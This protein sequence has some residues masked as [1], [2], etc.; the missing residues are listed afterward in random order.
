MAWSFIRRLSAAAIVLAGGL[1]AGVR[2]DATLDRLISAGKYK[3]AIEHADNN[4]PAP[5][6]NADVWVK[7]GEANE[8]V[9][10]TEKALACYLVAW[11]LDASSYNALLGAAKV[12]NRLGQPENA[13]D[14]AEKALELK[15]TG[16]ASWEYARASIQLKKPQEA[17]KALEKVIETDP[18]NVVANR[19]LGGIYFDEKKYAD[20]IPLLRKA[21][22]AKKDPKLSLRIG[23]AYREVGNLDSALTFIEAAIA[24]GLKSPEIVLDLARIYYG[25][26]QYEEAVR[27]FDQAYGKADFTA[28]D[29]CS[30]AVAKEKTNDKKGALKAYEA[31]VKAYGASTEPEA[32]QANLK[33][34]TAYFEQ[35]NYGGALTRLKAIKKADPK[36]EEVPNIN[37]LL[38]DVYQAMK[39]PTQ[40]IASLEKA[41]AKDTKNYEAYARLAELYEKNGQ[42]EK[43]RQTYEKMMKLSPNDPKVFL[44][45]GLYNLKSKKYEKALEL[46]TKSEQLSP[47]AEAEEGIA[48]AS[49]NLDQ[50]NRAR[51]AALK[52]IQRKPDLV[53]SR[54]ILAKVYLRAEEYGDA[55]KHLEFLVER[56]P[57]NLDHLKDLAESYAALNKPKKLAEVDAKIIAADKKNVKS[58]IRLAEYLLRNKELKGAYTHFRAAS[59]LDPKNA[60]VLGN[61]YRIAAELGKK[62]E[63]VTYVKKYLQLKPKDAERYRDLGDLQYEL[64]KWEGA[65]SAYRTALKLDPGLTGFYKRYADVVLKKGQQAEVIKALTTLIKRGQGDMSAYTTL[66]TLYEKQKQYKKALDVY[67]QALAIEP[68]NA[69]LLSSYASCQAKTGDINGAIITYEQAVMMNPKAKEEFRSLGRLYEKQKKP[70]QA[71][72]AY[73]K[74]L[75]R[76]AKDPKV[77]QNVGKY[78]IEKGKFDVAYKYLST[79]QGEAANDFDHLLLLGEAAFEIGKY[80]ETVGAYTR[81]LERKPKMAVKKQLTSTLAKAYEK[82]GN[83]VDAAKMYAAYNKLAG[84]RDAEAAYKSARL[85]EKANPS[86]AVAIYKTNV[87]VFP[88]DARNFLRLGLIYSKDKKKLQSS[89]AMLK[90]A[91]S[92]ADTVPKVWLELAQVYGE[93]GKEDDELK[94]YKQYAKFDAQNVLANKRIGLL[95]MKKGQTRDGMIYLETANALSPDDPEVMMALA[96]G[97]VQTNR[98]KEAIDL[99]MRVKKAQPKNAEVRYRIFSM[100]K[101]E[102][103]LDEARREMEQL[104]QLKRENKFLKEYAELLVKMDKVKE[105]LDKLEDILATDPENISALML[106]A[107]ILTMMEKYSDAI[108]IYKEISYI[109]PDHAEALSRRADVHLMESKIQ[110]ASTFYQ[111]ALR[112]DPKHASAYLGLAKVAKMTKRKDEYLKNIKQAYKLDPKDSE[113]AK[114]YAKAHGK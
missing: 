36:E 108:E 54:K 21:Y 64:K 58:R 109:D 22:S 29:H 103:R 53:E 11:R 113:I 25:R 24:G 41:I 72:K 105:A 96:E 48:I 65:L 63:A 49:I 17:K 45:L 87:K 90:K 82:M 99:L 38:A 94:A 3:E 39:K 37:F 28:K 106:K 43:A 16:E 6:R 66:G 32:I 62:T 101:G 95:L 1:V 44:V 15:F 26:G 60:D 91:A 114:E 92:L 71:M 50:W 46:L 57:K 40:A 80:K 86:A 68:Q 93:L 30:R 19:E 61:L 27:K 34:A 107:Q 42:A 78:A 104:L 35:K 112:A 33:V 56:F 70:E 88:K 59:M 102:G 97:Y 10:L 111:R 7:L 74:Y 12:Y 85:Q 13:R 73:M 8:A 14:M 77:A 69:E 18:N 20:A 83:N 100:L 23:Q 9:G 89:V 75:D 5:S 81:L 31:A 67:R 2:A 55:V 51:E 98:K 52:A 84:G 110:W 4:I 76:G 79:I 47:S